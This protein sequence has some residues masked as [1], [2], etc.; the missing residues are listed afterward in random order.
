VSESDSFITEVTEEVRRDKLFRIFKKYAWLLAL[1]VVGIVGGTAYLEWSK[2]KMSEQAQLTGDVMRAAIDAENPGALAN[3]ADEGNP[4]AVLAQFQLSAVLVDIGDIDGAVLALREIGD[5]AS[6]LTHYTDLAWLKIIMLSAADMD[7]DER[8]DIIASL[9][10]ES[11]PYRLLA[12]EQRAMQSI[13]DGAVSDALADFALI[14]LD[15]TAS[16]GLRN[17]AQQLTVSLGG[18]LPTDNANG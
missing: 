11:A 1:V 17:R 6:L 16:Q 8:A 5:D 2:A 12:I 9:T 13:R 3:I 4:A 18:S 10:L 7:A 14:L 15:S